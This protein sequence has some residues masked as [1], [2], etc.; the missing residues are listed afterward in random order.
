MIMDQ[1]ILT[2]L[3]KKPVSREMLYSSLA[4]GPCPPFRVTISAGVAQY[5]GE[6]MSEWLERADAALYEAK[7]RGRNTTCRA[8]ASWPA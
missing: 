6:G 7:A 3:F 2:F 1:E 4:E 5:H 8:S